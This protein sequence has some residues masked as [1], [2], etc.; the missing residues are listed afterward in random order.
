[1][2]INR[3]LINLIMT[4]SKKDL[5]QLLAVDMPNGYT[6]IGRGRVGDLPLILKEALTVATSHLI[7]NMNP[8]CYKKNV[9]QAYGVVGREVDK[10]RTLEKEIRIDN[11]EVIHYLEQ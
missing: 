4:D 5:G 3:N 9:N 11:P 6:Y 1:M 10:I 8:G 2:V 7:S